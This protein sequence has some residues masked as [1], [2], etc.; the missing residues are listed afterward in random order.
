[1]ALIQNEQILLILLIITVLLALSAIIAT[2]IL[3]VRMNNFKKAYVSLQTFM[4]K[5]NL[6]DLLKNNL[7]EL[8][9][10]VRKISEHDLRL[11]KIEAKLRKGIDRAELVRFNSFDHMGAELS[12]ALALLNQEG[13]GV[14]LTSIHSVEECRLYAKI[15]EN[16]QASVKLI[17][18][19]QR[20]LEK[21]CSNIKKV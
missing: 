15:I 1:L 19:E 21:A 8:Q 12:F 16:G 17:S 10:A 9:T 18:E 7:L 5:E 14:L 13:S 6:E 20:V 4:S 3:A 2:I 11:D